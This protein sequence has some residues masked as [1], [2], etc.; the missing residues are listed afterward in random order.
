MEPMRGAIRQDNWFV[1]VDPNWQPDTAED[2]PPSELMVGGWM[3]E[4]NGTLGP[5]H[6][7]PRYVPLTDS[8]PSDPIDAILQLITQGEDRAGEI[9]PALWNQVVQIAC[10]DNDRP[11]IGSA[12]DGVS[13]ALVV[14]AEIHKQRMSVPRWWP[15]IGRKLPEIMPPEADIL[16]NP[17]GDRQFRLTTSALRCTEH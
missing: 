13:C 4:A 10:D 7:N 15:V 11:V 12:P 3:V 14:T 8:T 16:V 5:F 2:S 9:V 17:N 6:P 1:L